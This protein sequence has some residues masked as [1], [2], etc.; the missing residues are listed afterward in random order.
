[1]KSS[2]TRSVAAG[3]YIEVAPGAV[4]LLAAGRVP[5]RQEEAV[6]VLAGQQDELGL[7]TVDLEP[8]A[9]GP[10]ETAGRA[11]GGRDLQRGPVGRFDQ[12][13][14]LQLRVRREVPQTG[15]AGA[16]VGR[17]R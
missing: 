2:C 6:L 17:K 7:L 9:A 14:Q 16:L 12:Q 8:H 13:L 5:E 15:E 10:A 3:L 11:V 1:L 4:G